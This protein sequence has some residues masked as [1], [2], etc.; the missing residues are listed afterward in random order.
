LG[1]AAL[2]LAVIAVAA[3]IATQS[4]LARWT[5]NE[6]LAPA[7]VLPLIGLGAVFALIGARAL[8]TALPLFALGVA[9]GILAEDGLLVMLDLIPRAATHLFYT[10]PL[11]YL[12]AGIALIGGA[13]W[14]DR[15]APPAAAIFGA[16]LGLTVKL[17]DPSLHAPAYTWTPLL[18]AFWIVLTVM[19]TLRGFW[20]GWFAIFG[21]IL[22][23]W[24][25]A[26]GLLYGGAALLPPKREPPPPAAPIPP[27]PA[28]GAERA[29][30]GLPEPDQRAPMLGGERF[31]QP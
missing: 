27:M 29:I 4:P 11:A 9:A 6:T 8:M 19:L 31:R 1:L 13:R 16:M 2:G 3:S 22:G 7:R 14:R 24:L 18:V 10:G 12:S 30:P 23:S 26:I 28:P 5:L 15:L 20:R 17:T 21:R 25:T